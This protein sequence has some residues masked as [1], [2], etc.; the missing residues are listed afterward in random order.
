MNR[1]TFHQQTLKGIG[2]LMTLSLSQLYQQLADQGHSDRMPALFVGHGSPLNAIQDNTFSQQWQELGQH[3]PRPQAILSVSAHWLTPGKTLVGGMK[4]PRTIHDFGGFPDELF[5]QQYPAP[6]A[7]EMARLTTT[8]IQQTHVQTDQDWGL[9]HGTWS[10]LLPMYPLA[11]IPVFQLSIDYGKPPRYHYE[12]ARDLRKLREKGVL[13]IGSGNIV[14]NL[15]A[16]NFQGI[17][18][19]WATEF[20]QQIKSYLDTDQPDG[21]MDFQQLGSLA[22]IAH[23]TYD[24]YLP[25]LYAIAQREP[26]DQL[27]YFNEGWDAGSISMRSFILS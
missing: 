23:P 6:G 10:V 26:E 4:Q 27:T 17:T 5:A 2:G 19:D 16:I 9:D 21:I 8:L 1:R 7:P 20:D 22:Q 18:P 24:H 11:D 25:L 14:H 13:I 15:R 3:L 12:L